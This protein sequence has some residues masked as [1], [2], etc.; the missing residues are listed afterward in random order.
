[1]LDE[2]EGGRPAFVRGIAIDMMTSSVVGRMAWMDRQIL[3][4]IAIE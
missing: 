4:K 1:M 3:A 2:A